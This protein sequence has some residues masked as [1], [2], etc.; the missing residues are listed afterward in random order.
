[1]ILECY[2]NSWKTLALSKKSLTKYSLT[3]EIESSSNEPEY[4]LDQAS[5]V[6]EISKSSM[7]VFQI[8]RNMR[9][10]E[11]NVKLESWRFCENFKFFLCDTILYHCLSQFLKSLVSYWILN[12]IFGFM[13]P[14]KKGDHF[15][16]WIEF[17][18]KPA[19]FSSS[20]RSRNF[21]QINWRRFVTFHFKRK[22]HFVSC[23]M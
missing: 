15:R 23:S 13:V 9:K 3:F 10:N 8:S 17:T 6:D 12:P 14:C 18:F 1:M 7:A 21:S 4:S 22:I 19:T 16:T 2:A 5:T 11:K 20:S